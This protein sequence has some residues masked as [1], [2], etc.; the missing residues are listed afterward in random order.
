MTTASY[1]ATGRRKTAIARVWLFNGQKGISI[2][3][4]EASDYLKR[5]NLRMI[6]EAP[7]KTANMAEQFRVK[8]KVN[9][10]G[11]AG[12][13]GAISL[14]IARAL[15]K[16]DENLRKTLR[17]GGFLTRDPRAKERK[18]PGRKGA[19]KSFQYTKR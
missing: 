5:S 1:Y 8:A 4:Q 7:L 6:V 10:G 9:G 14:G 11:I 19:R 3:G 2:N 18:K 15:L 12:Q 17:Q 13:A 16:V